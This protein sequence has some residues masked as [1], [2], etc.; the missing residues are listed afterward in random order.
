MALLYWLRLGIYGLARPS[1]IVKTLNNV[2]RERNADAFIVSYPKTGRTWLRVMLGH[3][4]AGKVPGGQDRLLDTYGLSESAGLKR[5]I[6]THDGPFLLFS[7]AP[8]Q[9]QEYHDKTY[10]SRDVVFIVL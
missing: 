9:Q 6:F 5:T 7:G 3:Y 10:R 4:M 1:K 8:Y 2:R